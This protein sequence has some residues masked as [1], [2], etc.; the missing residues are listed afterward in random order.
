MRNNIFFTKTKIKFIL[1][2]KGLGGVVCVHGGGVGVGRGGGR[3]RIFLF[4]KKF[5]KELFEKIRGG[6][7]YKGWR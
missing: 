2:W 6:G 4:L 3:S 1:F 5:I 7:G